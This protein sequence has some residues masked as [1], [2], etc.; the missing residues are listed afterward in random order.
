M[1]WLRPP[2]GAEEAANHSS[3]SNTMKTAARKNRRFLLLG[4]LPPPS[5]GQ[6]LSF[7][8]LCRE[9][10]GR[11]FDCRVVDLG[12]KRPSPWSRMSGGRATEV[13]SALVRFAADL[14]RGYRRIYLLIARSRAGFLRDLLFIW[15]AWLCGCRIVVHLKG[16]NYDGFYR[17]QPGFWRFLIRHTLRRV[18]RIIVLSERLRGMYAFDPALRERIVVVTNGPPR[19]LQGKPRYRDERTEGPVRLLFLSNLRQSKGYYDVL[20]AAAILCRTTT[21]RLQATFAGSF[22]S[23]PEDAIPMSPEEAETAFLERIERSGLGGIAHYAG[24]VTGEAKQRLLDTSDFFLLPTYC[25]DE[26]QPVSIIEAMSQGCVVI[27]TRF[28]A[29]PDMVMDGETGVLVD[30]G[31]PEQI[32]DAVRRI[33][34][35]AERYTAMSRAAV[36]RYEKNFTVRRH[37]DAMVSVLETV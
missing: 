35:D 3:P 23:M 37:M 26:G 33:A 14:A 11:G 4:D 18:H 2:V 13:C 20:E 29:I 27:A 12:R 19:A 1:T 30:H 25:M 34:G 6:S 32:A 17:E 22:L 5:H 10:P 16:G 7:E 36:E 15:S 31:R 24:P 28:G 9:L 21:M 8:M